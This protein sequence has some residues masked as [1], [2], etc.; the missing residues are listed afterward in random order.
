MT[1]RPSGDGGPPQD[2]GGQESERVFRTGQLP[3]L[4]LDPDSPTGGSQRDGASGSPREWQA[5]SEI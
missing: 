2:S 4:A 1:R 5:P 3:S